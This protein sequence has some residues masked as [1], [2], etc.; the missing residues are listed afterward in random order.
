MLADKPMADLLGETNRILQLGMNK[1]IAD[2]LPPDEMIQRLQKDVFVFSACKTHIELRE[3]SA[4]LMDDDNKIRSFQKFSR[5][6]AAIGKL[7]NE[8]YLRAEYNHAVG[9]AEMAAKWAA[10]DQEGERYY[11]QYRTAADDRV[12]EDHAALHNITLPAN[13]PFWDKYYPPNGWNCRCTV[14]EVNKDKYPAS[15]SAEASQK[16]LKATTIIG[17]DGKDR[18]E[19]FRFNPGKQ[20][21]IFPP[22]HPYRKVQDKIGSLVDG[23]Y[24]KA[25][26]KD[27][28]VKKDKEIRE[29]TQKHIPA[30]GLEM[31]LDNFKTGNILLTRRNVKNISDHF[32]DPSLKDMAKDIISIVKTSE[33]MQYS[34]LD[35]RTRKNK[36]NIDKK[37]ARGVSGYN[38]YWFMWKGEKYRLNVEIIGNKEH[39]Y[40]VNKIINTG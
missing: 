15:N 37:I 9:S 20:K 7:Y 23:L 17:R 14:V 16:G 5:E 13:D 27:I 6:A 22:H 25:Y 26:S 29:W 30:G 24:N 33:Y 2:N 19:M 35:K 39:P 21:V 32:T 38:Y 31:K 3:V 36:A 34:K 12:R 1:G 40:M 11:L 10:L 4:L 28:R 18:G 8:N